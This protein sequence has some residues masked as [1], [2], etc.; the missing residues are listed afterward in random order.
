MIKR[1]FNLKTSNIPIA[2]FILGAASLGSAFLGFF[3]DRLLA[4][5]FGAGQEL[6][7]YYAAFRIPD[8]IN[9]TLI[10]GAISAAIIP[11]FN[12]YW[13]KNQEQAKEFISNLLTLFFFSLIIISCILFLFAPALV[14][15]IAPG[16]ENEKKELT[17]MLT[18][19]MLLSP[20][21]LGISNVISG[22]LH[23]FSRFFVTS[24]SPIVYN[25]GIIFGILVFVP[26]LGLSGLAWGVTLGGL[27]HFLVQIP[28]F[29]HLGF[30]V[31]RT[32]K[33]F[34]TGVSKVLK[35][36]LPR[37]LGLAAAQINLIAMTAIGSMLITGS[38]AVF[39]LANH[40][41]RSLILLIAV[42]FSTATFPAMAKAF[43]EDEKKQFLEKFS[44][45]ARMVIFLIVPASMILFLFR[46][47]I[48]R[49][50][51]GTGQ[52]GWQDTRL[53]AACVALFSLS[54]FAY[55]LVLLLSKAF[56]A[57]R[58]TKTP[59]IS[60]VIAVA[61]N[62]GLCILF[63]LLLKQEGFF[64]DF[65]QNILRLEGIANI[66][67][68]ALPLAYSMSGIFYFLLLLALLKRKIPEFDLGLLPSFLKTISAALLMILT[69][70][71][72]LHFF[73]L[74]INTSTFFGI[75][76]QTIFSAGIGAIIYLIFSFI[77]K[78]AEA[79]LVFKAISERVLK[80]K[81]HVSKY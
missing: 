53:T 17:V 18:R 48:V 63:V 67:I 54:L 15:I 75:L 69:S 22:V 28:I 40:L 77:F 58:N 59:A 5:T 4:G 29:F 2:A 23:T 10:T 39:N 32:F 76:M 43:S 7:I 35:L 47:Q 31:K 42:P 66:N 68:V 38:I 20:I 3:R 45:S 80:Y 9:M 70:Y 44:L 16:F 24:L 78:S 34:D 61:L 25:I 19:I 60:S 50:I 71:F 55:G 64:K 72:S 51:Y 56:Y 36:M 1:A 49:I 33:I 57:M 26:R 12:S 11:I 14:S 8:F 41:S 81:K 74:F 21:L 79:I 6:D 37:S 30:R 13:S 65:L 73:S 46:A 62:I 27:L 52:F